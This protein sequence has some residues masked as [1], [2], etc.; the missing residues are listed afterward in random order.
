MMLSHQYSKTAYRICALSQLMIGSDGKF[1]K[2]NLE[3]YLPSVKDTTIAA[4]LPIIP[5]DN[6]GGYSQVTMGNIQE[7][8]TMVILELKWAIV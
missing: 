4:G 2:N 5:I 3:V 6:V 7:R 8:I 1:V